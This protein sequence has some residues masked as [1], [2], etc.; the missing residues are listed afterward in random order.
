M[1][2]FNLFITAVM[3]CIFNQTTMAEDQELSL[4]DQMILIVQFRIRLDR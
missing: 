4:Y 2:V 3:F 1:H